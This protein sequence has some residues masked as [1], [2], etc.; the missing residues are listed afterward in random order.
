MAL[1]TCTTLHGHSKLVPQASLSFRPTVYAV[2]LQER[3]V[4]LITTRSTG[5]YY[6]PGGAIELGERMEDALTREVR[7]ETGLDV[8]IDAL[9]HVEEQFFFHDPTAEAW[10]ALLFFF[11]CTPTAACSPDCAQI[12][13]REVAAVH[14]HDVASLQP[15]MFQLA[16]HTVVQR[17]RS[18]LP[19]A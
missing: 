19:L 6:F 16:A 3:Q 10:H 17:L 7:E 11:H 12:D 13:T 5:K 9:L 8:R 15:A 2:I 1:I 18:R 4:L 14:W